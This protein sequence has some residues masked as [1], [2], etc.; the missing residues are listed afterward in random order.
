MDISSVDRA[1]NAPVVAITDTAPD[2][3]AETRSIVK[4]VKAVNGTEMFG[5]DNLL[6][7]QR[8]PETKRMVIQVIDQKTKEVVSQIPPE[9][10]LRLAEDMKDATET[11]A[12][13][14]M[15]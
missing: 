15:G 1:M 8:D 7:F 13:A 11:A 2:R 6:M 14:N 5:R 3:T 12:A 4:A 9:Y 10:L